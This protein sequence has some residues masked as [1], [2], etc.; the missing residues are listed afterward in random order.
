[1]PD[2]ERSVRTG[3][4]ASSGTV[5]KHRGF[6]QMWFER[7]VL[8][9][10]LLAPALVLIFG[11]VFYPVVRTLWLSFTDAGLASIVSGE[12]NFVGF[13]N[14]AEIV[15]DAH[16]RRVFF[17]T[18]I[19]GFSCVLG[20]MLLGLAV[21]LLLNMSFKGRLLF[22]VLVLLPWAVPRVGAAI[23]WRWMFNDQYGIVNWLLSSVGLSFFD[24]FAWLNSALP[25]FVAI[26]VVV[27]WQSFPFVALS[28]LAGL[29]AIPPEII[30]AAKLDGA[31]ALQR[32]RL[33]TL[34][35]L[36]PLILVLVVIS[37]IWDFKIFDQVY[38]MTGGGPA[39][40]TEVL[41]IATWVEAFTQLDFGLGSALAITLFVVLA[42][43]TA[44]YIRLI[45]EE[46]LV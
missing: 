19:F 17:V 24:N 36:K 29:Q 25:A 20:T 41:E 28:L 26:G 38:V 5:R 1:M 18:A 21:A 13:E 23:V 46:E 35:M 15:T 6:G 14:Y 9:L 43:I 45:R 2:G 42:L 33:I 32:L 30:E 8:P 7:R 22:G 39:R 11:L 40:S 3:A 37:T 10:L 27:V 44:L 31:N 16:L 12:M 34:P 4:A